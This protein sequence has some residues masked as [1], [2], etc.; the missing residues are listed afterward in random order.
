MIW[1]VGARALVIIIVDVGVG[2]K[3]GATQ[4]TLYS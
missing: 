1:R 2:Q 3:E 4:E